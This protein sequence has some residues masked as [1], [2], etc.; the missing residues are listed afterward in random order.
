M[1][2]LQIILDT[3]ASKVDE[4]SD[5]L[6]DIG[7]V[8]VTWLD[9]KDQPMYEPS[10]NTT[11]L[12]EYTR[13]IALFEDEIDTKQLQISNLPP[14]QIQTLED[15]EWVRVWM[16][17]FHPMQFGKN[18]WICPS[19]HT[20]PD[21]QATNIILDPGLAF[22]TGTH[23][24]TSLC[25]EWLDSQNDL[26][27]KTVIDYGCGS[28]ILA[29]TAAKLGANHIWAVD[30]DPQALEA[31]ENNS[32]KNKVEKIIT[33]VLPAQ[34]PEHIEADCILANI[35]ATP[36]INLAST[37]ASH[38]NTN[39]NIVLSGILQEQTKDIVIAYQPYFEIKEETEQD[40][41]MR[42]VGKAL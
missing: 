41:W 23:I 35:L 13:I 29:I 14:Y 34:L 25:L 28:G 32:K 6:T 11:P 10:L 36:L 37:M 1:T 17:D 9:A 26:T 22:G 4:I 12:W 20:P 18:I 3:E 38:V 24:T 40:G 19:W 2:W 31:T 42:I 5:I 27:D 16:D 21:L 39:S 15:K 30:N 33:P 7:A 8:S